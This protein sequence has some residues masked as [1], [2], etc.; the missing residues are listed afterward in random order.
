MSFVELKTHSSN[1]YLLLVRDTVEDSDIC[2]TINIIP[3]LAKRRQN[4]LTSILQCNEPY[5]KATCMMLPTVAHNDIK[6]SLLEVV[7]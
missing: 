1:I 3:I 6:L 5:D 2:G 4:K 7:E